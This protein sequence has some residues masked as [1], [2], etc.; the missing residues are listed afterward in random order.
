MA[1][2]QGE[3]VAVYALPQLR[4]APRVR[5][6][7]KCCKIDTLFK[8]ASGLFD[9]CFA[10]NQPAIRQ[11]VDMKLTIGGLD[12]NRTGVSGFAIRWITTLPRGLRGGPVFGPG[13][14]L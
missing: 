12:Q 3:Y 9:T 1:A 2:Q 10:T 4:I 7:Q 6:F 5:F 11:I 13:G 14:V 8:L